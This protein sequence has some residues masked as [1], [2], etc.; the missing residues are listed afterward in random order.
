MAGPPAPGRGAAAALSLASS[1]AKL[2]AWDS[3]ASRARV[4]A[5]QYGDRVD[6]GTLEFQVD[7]LKGGFCQKTLFTSMGNTQYE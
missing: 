5:S 2:K 4:R 6:L 3:G 7:K 1:S